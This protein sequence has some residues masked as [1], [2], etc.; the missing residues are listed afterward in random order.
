[1]SKKVFLLILVGLLVPLF[2]IQAGEIEKRD[3]IN[4][5]NL[6]LINSKLIAPHSKGLPVTDPLIAQSPGYVVG[7]TINDYQT[8]GS[9]G[10]RVAVDPSGRLHYNW[11]WSDN[12]LNPYT[13]NPRHIW[14]G[15]KSLT[16]PTDSLTA[17]QI[18]SRN[19]AGYT[20]LDYI[21]DA[22][23][24]RYAAVAFYHH[25]PGP[26]DTSLGLVAA[27]DTFPYV[28]RFKENYNIPQDTMDNG[29]DIAWPYG[30]VDSTGRIHM[31]ATESSVPEV[32]TLQN[33]CYWNSSDNGLTWSTRLIIDTTTTISAIV[34]SSPV[35][36]KSAIAYCNPRGEIMTPT[37]PS[38]IDNDIW[39]IESTNGTVWDLRN[40]RK[41]I[42]NYLNVPTSVNDTVMRAYT[43]LDVLYD[44]NDKLH[45]LW[46]AP[47]MSIDTVGGVTDTVLLYRTALWHWTNAV[48]P[49]NGT[50]TKVF[51]H[52]T[53]A[54]RCSMG[55][56]NM[57]ISKMS[58]SIDSLNN[59]F[60]VF[61]AFNS[62]DGFDPDEP[63]Q[64]DCG[65]G[66][67]PTACCN[68]DI[69]VTW[70]TNNG[71]NWAL[72]PCNMTFSFSP[73]CLPDFCESDNWSSA[74]EIASYDSL[75]IL[76]I[77]D[78]DAGGVVQTE[79]DPTLNPVML[80]NFPNPVSHPP[81]FAPVFPY[82]GGSVTDTIAVNS[83]D[84]VYILFYNLG[85][86]TLEV[87]VSDTASWLSTFDTLAGPIDTMTL[88]PWGEMILGIEFNGTGL[89]VGELYLADLYFT[90]NDTFAADTIIVACSLWVVQGCSYLLGDINSDGQRLGGDVTYGVRY[91]KGT[92]GVPP[93][94]CYN[95][96]L[97]GNGYLY[98]AGDVNGNCEFRGSDI[99]RLVAYFKGN[100]A[101]AY[102]SYFP[103][104]LRLRTSIDLWRGRQLP[105]IMPSITNDIRSFYKPLK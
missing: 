9:S 76:Y 105:T 29:N 33:L 27:I 20:N 41:N 16:N 59:L 24:S 18:N 52:P 36:K 56:W 95:A 73:D 63:R 98:V 61:T 11:M 45:I 93:D 32:T 53:R 104:P 26:P 31:V 5:S 60:A 68:G 94:S 102:C 25:V 85:D 3:R 10:N 14:Y 37:G 43:D 81:L 8:N 15:Y 40:A 83:R 1:M 49:P 51:E 17:R 100:A 42:T 62:N 55:A 58:L 2:V 19:R 99:T 54:W 12:I 64:G 84:S 69:Y 82:S 80:M 74:S 6:R 71:T 50:I 70:S 91:F 7:M 72:Q 86:A 13:P 38:Q 87:G 97:P 35:S 77:N 57:P 30:S 21:Y 48:N 34:A 46:N 67:T 96:A 65:D 75:H 66:V 39:Y 88:P 79:G 89:N 47:Y 103:P 92:G 101:L 90:S 44:F 78:K 22:A 23:H 28:A 4:A